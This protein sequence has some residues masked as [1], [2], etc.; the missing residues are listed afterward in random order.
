M[1]VASRPSLLTWTPAA[2]RAALQRAG[3]DVVAF[4][5]LRR[6]AAATSSYDSLGR[7]SWP[8]RT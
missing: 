4:A 8:A 3:A 7:E 5:A 1:S 2:D 6:E